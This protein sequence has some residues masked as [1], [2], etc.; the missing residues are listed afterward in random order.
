MFTCV[1]T[2][3][4]ALV[5]DPGDVVAAWFC[6]TDPHRRSVVAVCVSVAALLPRGCT[7]AAECVV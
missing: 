4:R 2:T 5:S 1:C 7:D 3:T 6:V